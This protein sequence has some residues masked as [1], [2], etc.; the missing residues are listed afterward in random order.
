MSS[1]NCKNNKNKDSCAVNYCDEP[2]PSSAMIVE[3]VPLIS[4]TLSVCVV[5][6]GGRLR[7]E[8]N[9]DDSLF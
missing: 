1:A 7:H 6:C 3:F 4:I 2:S 8:I 5:V 9:N